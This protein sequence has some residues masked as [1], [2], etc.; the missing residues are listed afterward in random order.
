MKR[1][2]A[3][4][5]ALCFA[6][7]FSACSKNEPIQESTTEQAT[8]K[9]ID[10]DLT[11]LSSTMV[12]SEVY[13]MMIYPDQYVGKTIKMQGQY[14]EYYDEETDKTYYA[15]VIADAT[16]CCQQGLEFEVVNEN[17]VASLSNNDNIEV[18]GTFGI[19][20]EGKLQYFH[21]T[22]ASVKGL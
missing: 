4:I 8:V 16:A 13:N 2:I 21:L 15:C 10:V 5:C 1:L 18:V 9:A 17:D 3:I 14:N 6:L 20:N 7:S 12:Y 11:K 22:D 19:Y